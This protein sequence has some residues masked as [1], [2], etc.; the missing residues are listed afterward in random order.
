M[1]YVIKNT[2]II[3][4]FNYFYSPSVLGWKQAK[5]GNV[6]SCVAVCEYINDPSHVKI[7]K[8]KLTEIKYFILFCKSFF[9]NS[10]IY[11]ENAKNSDIPQSY[12]LITNN[13]IVRVRYLLIYG[14]KKSTASKKPAATSEEVEFPQRTNNF[15]GW[16]RKNPLVVSVVLY[17]LMLFLVGISKHRAVE[18]YKHVLMRFLQNRFKFL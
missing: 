18:Y 9:V 13:E 5:C 6:M 7:R 4:L 1:S 11:L 2:I 3:F 8:G 17:I 10:N 16:C 14:S 15:F 12:L